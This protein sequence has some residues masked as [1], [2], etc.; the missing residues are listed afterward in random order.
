VHTEE[1]GIPET[2]VANIAFGPDAPRLDPLE[3]A[4]LR[5]VDE[6]VL[7]GEVS[8]ETWPALAQDLTT[9]QILDLVFTVGC[10][11]MIVWVC[12]SLQFEVEQDLPGR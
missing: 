12:G 7:D 2:D 8:R 9:Q 5:A 1:A 10:Y 6:L 3:S 4:V 11:D